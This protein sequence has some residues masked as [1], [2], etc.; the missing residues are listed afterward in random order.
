VTLSEQVQAMVAKQQVLFGFTGKI[1]VQDASCTPCFQGI[2]SSRSKKVS[3]N[4]NPLA[5][6]EIEELE[7]K[8]RRKDK[9][10][11]S[12]KAV[13]SLV[14]HELNHHGGNNFKGCPRSLDLYVHNIITPVAK[15]LQSKGFPN[16][17]VGDQQLYYYM[18][19]LVSDV[20]DNCELGVK[21]DHGGMWV[22]Y[23]DDARH[24]GGTFSE[25]FDAFVQLQQRICGRSLAKKLL[26]GTESKSPKVSQAIDLVFK[27]LKLDECVKTVLPKKHSRQLGR[28]LLIPKSEIK[29]SD[30]RSVVS[31]L[32]EEK[33]WKGISKVIVEE[34]SKLIDKSKLKNPEYIKKMFIPI[35][36]AIDGF[37]EE[38]LSD[39]VLD[40][41]TEAEKA[42]TSFVPP[43]FVVNNDALH[44]VYKRLARRLQVKV[45]TASK[46]MQLPIVKYGNRP[47]DPLQ[48]PIQDARIK[49]VRGK[50][51]LVVQPFS[52]EIPVNYVSAPATLPCVTVAILDCSSSMQEAIREPGIVMNPW[53]PKKKQWTSGSKYHYALTAQYGVR[54]LMEKHG[55]LK[56]SA[57][58]SIV[59]SSSTRCATDEPSSRKL[60]LDPEFG[61]TSLDMQKIST[62]FR[63]N[64]LVI[65]TS[66]GAISNW[67][68]WLIPPE[69]DAQGKE[70][71]TGLKIKD[72]YIRHAKNNFYAH[73]QIGSPTAMSQDLEN[74]GINVKYDDGSGLQKIMIDITTPF[75]RRQHV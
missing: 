19:N 39:Y 21:T 30:S 62:L 49:I 52:I 50:P 23:A 72:E 34:F 47:F 67:D 13:R 24:S 43:A 17:I 66:D 33:N 58:R 68:E 3:V 26:A 36:S 53:A 2:A 38:E 65:S 31:Y 25:L 44:Y 45:A 71:K 42:G 6:K 74:A 69:T 75:L 12:L 56:H 16:C 54:D 22:V 32:V 8:I 27:R 11:L 29:Y 9:E 55:T 1:I 4:Y 48:D 40:S 37:T 61:G 35:A 10:P 46:S 60:L 59:F 51:A 20:I 63:K 14:S 28:R 18:S 70:I 5:E 7:L 73:I 41:Y 15:V 57:Y 64:E